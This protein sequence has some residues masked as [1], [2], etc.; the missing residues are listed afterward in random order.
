M[1]D[2][3]GLGGLVG[4][5]NLGGMTQGI[6]GIVMVIIGLALVGAIV[7][8]VLEIRK[9]KHR[10]VVKSLTSSRKSIVFDKFKEW[11][12]KDGTM[13][14][15][16]MRHR[17]TIIPAPAEA[18]ELMQNGIYFVEVYKD[19]EGNFT[20]AKDRVDSEAALGTG[21]QPGVKK[22]KD[23]KMLE[24]KSI[25]STIPLSTGQRIASVNQLHKAEARKNQGILGQNAGKI[26]IGA[27]ILI[28]I[29]L[30]GIF[31][32]NIWKPALEFGGSLHQTAETM[33]KVAEKFDHAAYVIAQAQGADVRP[34]Q[35]EE[36]PR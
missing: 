26:I 14:Y 19:S 18:I 17:V 25:S 30:L 36:A 24:T 13:W 3:L 20:Y 15:R 22:D 2:D 5:M 21:M 16:L 31:S 29:V 6:Y 10:I 23:G 1:V 11:K 4:S 12:D 7:W 27:T 9:F 28:A 32:E 33:N 34:I 35:P 8:M